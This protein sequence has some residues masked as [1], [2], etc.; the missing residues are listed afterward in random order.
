[1]SVNHKP[2]TPLPWANGRP[3]RGVGN[4]IAPREIR[5]TDTSADYLGLNVTRARL[6]RDAFYIVHTANSYPKLID[7]LRSFVAR[8]NTNPMDSAGIALAAI[9]VRTL[10][11][12]LGEA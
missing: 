8:V 5:G 10:L 9:E 2:A 6:E 4:S 12:D 3:P 7:A 11:R 1:M